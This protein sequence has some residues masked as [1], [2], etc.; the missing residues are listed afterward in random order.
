M[1]QK[2]IKALIPLRGGSKSIPYKNIKLL[3][4]KPLFAWCADAALKSGLFSD[5][6][7][8]TDDEKIKEC[9][10]NHFPEIHVLHRPGH[11]ASDTASTESVM[12]HFAQKIDFDVLCLIQATSPLTTSSDF[13]KAYKIF[14]NQ[15][16][17]SLVTGVENKRFFWN[18]NGKP[19]NYDPLN[20]PRRQ[21]FSGSIMENGAFY[22]TKKEILLKYK[23][24]LA[25]KI[26]VYKMKD[27]TAQ[28]IDEPSD[29]NT[30]ASYLKQNDDK[31]DHFQ[32]ILPGLTHINIRHNIIKKF[33]NTLAVFIDVDGTLTDGGMYYGSKGEM[34]KKFNTKDA[35]GMKE[36]EKK[37]IVICII[38][39]EDSPAVHARMQKLGLKHYFYGIK[40]KLPVYK[41]FLEKHSLNLKQT[42]FIGDDNGDVEC[43]RTAG[44]GVV[45]ADGEY[46]AKE[47][48]DYITARPGGHGAVREVC[49]MILNASK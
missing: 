5:V 36:L 13:T 12:L 32:K 1:K 28:E 2:N 31:N 38:T 22:F 45:P 33:K 49:D 29:W 44:I 16:A 34:L 43:L 14:E 46:T 17:D 39:A 15:N 48:A 37:G 7:V 24:R 26:A 41:N 35:H 6:Y 27:I 18:D 21:D 10:Q 8:S 40:N 25:G 47:A 30:V 23:S 42:V 19:I 3:A 4:G 9:V 11:L 20:R